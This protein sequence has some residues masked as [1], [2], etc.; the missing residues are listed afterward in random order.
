[1]TCV[2]GDA[3]ELASG[4]KTGAVGAGD[5]FVTE[6]EWLAEVWPGLPVDAQTR[7]LNIAR[8]AAEPGNVGPDG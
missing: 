4:A 7:I 8:E 1:V 6:F 5:K 2:D 3:R